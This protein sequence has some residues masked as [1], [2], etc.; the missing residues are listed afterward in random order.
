MD[1]DNQ[2]VRT[3]AVITKQEEAVRT[4][5]TLVDIQIDGKETPMQVMDTDV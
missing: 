1:Y 4:V 5:M 2:P 3:L